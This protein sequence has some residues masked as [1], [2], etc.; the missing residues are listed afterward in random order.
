M[1]VRLGS[2]S[3]AQ[4]GAGSGCSAYEAK[5]AWQVDTGC[6]NR[7]IADV[8]AVADPQTG[9]AVYHSYA[10]QGRKGWMVFGGT[11]VA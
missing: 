8:S 11:S 2:R 10:F 7:S 9:V 1:P 5:P 4:D 6:A 3:F